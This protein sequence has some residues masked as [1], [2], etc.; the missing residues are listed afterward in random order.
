MTDDE[1]IAAADAAD[2]LSEQSFR[3]RLAIVDDYRYDKAQCKYW[4]VVS[5]ELYAAEAVDASIAVADWPTRTVATRG[6]G[7]RVVAIKPSQEIA[8]IENGLMVDGSTWW[9][10]LPDLIEG[11]LVTGRGA[12]PQAGAL[13]INT[14]RAP[15]HSQLKRTKNADKWIKHV[16]TLFPDELEHE[17]FFDYAAHM[18]QNPAE[19]TNHGI[20][21]SGAQGIGKDTM[22]LPIRYGVGVWNVAEISP[23]NIEDRFNGFVK[24]VMLVVNEVRPHNEEHRASG[25]YNRLKPYLAA[26]P[27]MLPMEMKH[28]HLIYV[29]NVLRVFLTTNDPLTMHIPAED[30]RLFVMDSRIQKGWARPDYFDGMFAYFKDGGI[31]AVIQWL[32]CR[33]I[34]H[35]RPGAM[36]PM[37]VGKQRIIESTQHVRRDAISDAFDTLVGDGPEPLVFFPSDLLSMAFDNDLNLEKSL[38]AKNLHYRIADLGYYVL[39]PTHSKEWILK[40]NIEGSAVAF[41]SRS[42]FVH[43]SIDPLTADDEILAAMGKRLESKIKVNSAAPR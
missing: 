30:R 3:R 12:Q 15:D 10:G 20:V 11:Q 31:D 14:Y 7:Q 9:P 16:K 32:L 21:L 1:L 26:P 38:K 19:K 41:R 5:G 40:K 22:L 13:T 35:F 25:F 6:G 27:E 28:A 17:H 8:R 33:D 34:A 23:D 18:L 2:E 39:R 37:T 43:R 24:S 42:A 29:A 4:D 36:P